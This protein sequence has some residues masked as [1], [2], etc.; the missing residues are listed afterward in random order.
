MISE[1]IS[2][3]DWAS[4]EGAALFFGTAFVVMVYYYTESLFNIPKEQ[5]PGW[6]AYMVLNNPDETFA[7]IKRLIVVCLGAEVL[8]H[9]NAL[10][11]EQILT[12]GAAC[13]YLAFARRSQ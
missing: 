2:N 4:L 5:R 6:F 9:T 12:S 1:Y 10:N 8:G 7:A 11:V 3:F 13:G